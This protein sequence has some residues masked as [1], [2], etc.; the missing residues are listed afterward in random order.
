[1]PASSGSLR[2]RGNLG[3]QRRRGVHDAQ[4]AAAVGLDVQVPWII[5]EPSR[6]WIV[7]AGKRRPAFGEMGQFPHLVR[8]APTNGRGHGLGGDRLDLPPWPGCSLCGCGCSARQET[9]VS[10]VCP[11]AR[12]EEQVLVGQDLVVDDQYVARFV[13]LWSPLSS[14]LALGH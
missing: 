10:R 14:V 7:G 4:T 9:S 6:A 8:K 11:L 13:A 1:M 2:P 3:R 5:G 12:D